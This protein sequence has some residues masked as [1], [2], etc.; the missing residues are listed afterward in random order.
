MNRKGYK[1]FFSIFSFVM[2]TILVLG[3][4]SLAYANSNGLNDIK[5]TYAEKE[6]Q[7][8]YDDGIIN[9]YEDGSF[10]PNN[11]ISRAELAKI[12]YKTL[13]LDS[14]EFPDVNFEDVGQTWFT[15]YV[16]AV[17]SKGIMV[18]KSEKTFAPNDNVTREEIATIFIRIMGLDEAS[19]GENS[20]LDITDLDKIGQWAM[21]PVTLVMNFG[22]I[23]PV[24]NTDGTKS[25]APKELADRQLVAKLAYE[26][27]Y[28]IQYYLDIVAQAEKPIEQQNQDQEDPGQVE[29]PSYE[30][31]VSK[32]MDRFSS[33]RSKYERDLNNL[34]SKALQEIESGS[35]IDEVMLKYLDLV[36]IMES[37]ADAEFQSALS[38]F[39]AELEEYGYDTSIINE[40]ESEYEALKD[41]IAEE[42]LGQL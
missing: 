7:K 31:I 34:I 20:V 40:A 2:I 33:L 17:Y 32:Y 6:I 39:K 11:S 42:I 9:G 36:D 18:G 41:E 4:T 28:N 12:L 37:S 16:K 8:L 5:G 10:K 3:Q 15:S 23:E 29:K 25:F 22:L 13:E 35:S 19:F 14:E 27:K 38:S 26:A 24:M 21:K 30:S 1:K